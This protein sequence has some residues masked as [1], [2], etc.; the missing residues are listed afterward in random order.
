MIRFF[1]WRMLRS[2]AQRLVVQSTEHRGDIKK[3][4]GILA[5]AARREFTEENKPSLD[6]FLREC[7]E[8]S[9]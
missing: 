8:E 7:F 9:L 5:D 3:Y 6:G 2:I 1:Q 4:Y